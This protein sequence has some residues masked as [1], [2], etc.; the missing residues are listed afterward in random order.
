[1][2]ARGA[3]QMLG[4]FEHFIPVAILAGIFALGLHV[5]AADPNGAQLVG[6]NAP[7]EYLLFARLDVEEPL[8]VLFHQR[9]GKGPAVGAELQHL[10]LESDSA[11]S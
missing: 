2:G 9:N 1:M 3:A 10:T 11:T 5:S 7:V 6:P 8:P 4:V